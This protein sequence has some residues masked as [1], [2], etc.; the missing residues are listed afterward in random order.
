MKKLLVIGCALAALL[1]TQ[2]ADAQYVREKSIFVGPVVALALQG[3]N[4]FFIG[5]N[6]EYMIK[7]D[8]GIG[9]VFRYFSYTARTFPDGGS[10]VFN[11]EIIGAQA[12]YHF[13][14]P[15]QEFDPVIGA[16]VGLEMFQGGFKNTTVT[17]GAPS[18]SSNLVFAITAGARYF[19]TDKL[20]AALRLAFGSNYNALELGLDLSL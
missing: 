10:Y 8:V 18:G 4:S 17:Y 3:S 1:L 16:L 9:G 2:N 19:L 13:K 11:S 12:N 20:S 14:M 5:A 7:R 6:F 15:Q